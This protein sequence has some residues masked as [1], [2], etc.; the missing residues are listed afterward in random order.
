MECTRYVREE[1]PYENESNRFKITNRDFNRQ[2]AHIYSTR[3]MKFQPLLQYR[4]LEK[5]GKKYETKKLVQ[6]KPNEKAVVFGTIY[7]Q[8][9]LKPS[10]LR[11]ISDEVLY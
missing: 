1:L 5:W 11:E 10:I 2:Y 4:V 7:K 3:L 6:L 8:Q 9:E